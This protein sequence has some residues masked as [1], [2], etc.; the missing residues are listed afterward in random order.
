MYDPTGQP[1]TGVHE[2]AFG[3][4]ENDTLAIQRRHCPVD[5]ER[6]VPGGQ[7]VAGLHHVDAT[8]VSAARHSHV[9]PKG[10]CERLESRGADTEILSNTNPLLHGTHLRQFA[11]MD[12]VNKLVGVETATAGL[13]VQHATF[14]PGMVDKD[15]EVLGY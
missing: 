10:V 15:T 13:S 11:I 14:T 1:F 8:N 4:M 3:V 7:S 6:Y 9:E 5:T 2:E 12:I